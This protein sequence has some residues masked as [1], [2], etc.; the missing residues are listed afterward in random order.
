MNLSTME[1]ALKE[2]NWPYKIPKDDNSSILKICATISSKILSLSW[3]IYLV[4]SQLPIAYVPGEEFDDDL[5]NKGYYALEF[6]V[7]LD[8]PINPDSRGNLIQL[9]ALANS[10]LPLPGFQLNV[11][12][13]TLFYRYIWFYHQSFIEPTILIVILQMIKASLELYAPLIKKV[14]AGVNDLAEAM[15]EWS[16]EL[17]ILENEMDQKKP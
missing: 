13:N 17:S 2:L 1:M 9:L 11:L 3:P 8:Y 6:L 15:K 5:E 10:N 7:H 12:D 4:P 14:A 16:N